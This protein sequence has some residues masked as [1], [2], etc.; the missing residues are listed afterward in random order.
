MTTRKRS[1]WI[2]TLT[3]MGSLLFFLAPLSLMAYRAGDLNLLIKGLTDRIV[4]VP[5]IAYVIIGAAL[6][7]ILI[8]AIVNLSVRQ[9]ERRQLRQIEQIME[10]T[11]RQGQGV[12]PVNHDDSAD[13]QLTA[14]YDQL[15]EK[16]VSL[17][18]ELQTF[19]S[20]PL[21]FDGETR[22]QILEGERHR[23]ARELHDSV[24]QQLFAAMMMLSALSETA[25]QI[26]LDPNYQQMIMRIEKVINEAQSEMRALLLHLRPTN[27]E[28]RSLKDGI[29]SLL[30]ELQTKIKIKITWEMDDVRLKSG[31]ED[32]LFRIVQELLSNTLRHAHADQMQVYLKQVNQNVL[33][34]VVDNGVGFDMAQQ[35]NAGSYGLSNIRERAES[36]GGSVRTISFKNE[37][38]SVEVRV[39]IVME[40][41]HD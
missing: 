5:V 12:R 9:L 41:N 6:F 14:S 7:G 26:D 39:P 3:T 23:L 19:S 34:R 33:L 27:L 17:Q 36:V 2:F 15:N 22:E 4:S 16:I 25:Q 31:V 30:K 21:R 1:I 13:D 29:I 11:Y 28:G 32:N 35:E 8:V 37:G 20:Q 10:G 24:S 38:T 40:E 18:Q